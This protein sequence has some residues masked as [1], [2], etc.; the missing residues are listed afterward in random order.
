MRRLA[1][2]VAALAVCA[3]CT[4]AQA[5]AVTY[6]ASGS[7]NGQL[8][9]NNFSFSFVS[10]DFITTD[11]LGVALSNCSLSGGA[12]GFSCG[13][14]NFKPHFDVN[15]DPS[16]PQTP[17]YYDL[18]ELGYDDGHGGTGSGTIFFADGTFAQ[19]GIFGI[20]ITR[21][22]VSPDA[23]LT[24]ASAVPEPSTWAMM[25]LGF[26]GLGTIAYRRKS[27]TAVGVA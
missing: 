7:L 19:L 26:V 14:S 23:S 13:P 21:I 10:A 2:L 5:S 20:D 16:N 22:G 27:R 6:S 18:I 15:F 9:N 24:I 3:I 4:G 12:A 8:G 11:V 25:I 17:L 1:A